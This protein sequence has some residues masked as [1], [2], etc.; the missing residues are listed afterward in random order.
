MFAIDPRRKL[1]RHLVREVFKA[2]LRL[3]LRWPSIREFKP[4]Y[5]II[6]GTPWDLRHLLKANLLFVAKADLTRLHR[7][8]VVFDR[9]TQPDAE[10]FIKATQADFPSLPLEFGFHPPLAGRVA[11]LANTSKFYAGLNWITGLQRCQTRYAFLHDFDLYPLEP[12]YF[13]DIVSTMEHRQLWFSGAEYTHLDAVTDDDRLIGTWSLGIDLQNLRQCFRP[14]QCF[15]TYA[16][17][18]NRRVDLDAFS[19]VQSRTPTEKRSVADASNPDSFV[20]AKNLCATYHRLSNGERMRPRVAWRLHFLWY[21]E[22]LCGENGRL[23]EIA[24]AMRAA[25]SPVLTVDGRALDFSCVH[26]TCSNVLRDDLYRMECAQFGECRPIVEDYAKE[27]RG[28][29]ERFGETTQV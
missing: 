15:H 16:R 20:H 23:H 9:T 28:F 18:G 26:P 25:E 19:F 11:R 24:A 21:L 5:S 2:P 8:Y 22:S 17:M 27:F 12:G 4:G 3:L 1:L 29:L 14:A 10:A 7:L 6:L 13:E